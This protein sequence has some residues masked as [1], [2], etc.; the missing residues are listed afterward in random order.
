MSVP[1][2]AIGENME[3]LAI[4]DGGEAV[5]VTRGDKT[6]RIPVR[7]LRGFCAQP[8]SAPFRNGQR[9][10]HSIE[11]PSV[12]KIRTVTR[13]QEGDCWRIR[14]EGETS[15]VTVDIDQL[16]PLKAQERLHG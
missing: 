10:H 5:L 16:M 12:V 1:E 2:A 8:G 6:R 3:C 7:W 15:D 13:D 14:F 9:V 4:V 11:L